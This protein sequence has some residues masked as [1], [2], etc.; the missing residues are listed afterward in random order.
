MEHRLPA[1]GILSILSTVLALA[2]VEGTLIYLIIFAVLFPAAG[3]YKKRITILPS[4]EKILSIIFL[5]V[6]VFEQL[7]TET[8]ILHSLAHCLLLMIALKI[9]K[10][11]SKRELFIV[12][13]ASFA[14]MVLAASTTRSPLLAVPLLIY[15]TSIAFSIR[16][17]MFLEN[18]SYTVA[19]PQALTA[20]GAAILLA[21]G[22]SFIPPYAQ[23]YLETIFADYLGEKLTIY[24]AFS[25][26][27][28]FG[29]IGEMNMNRKVVLRVRS[30]KPVKLK[31]KVFIRYTSDGWRSDAKKSRE[32]LPDEWKRKS[33]YGPVIDREDGKYFSIVPYQKYFG[34]SLQ[35]LSL[36]LGVQ[37][38]RSL[39]IPYNAIG[40]QC[41]LPAVYSDNHGAIYRKASLK[42]I[43]YNC[44]YIP[45][46][47]IRYLKGSAIL[48]PGVVPD[49]GLITQVPD[50]LKSLLT[51]VA[52]QI[53]DP[54]SSF[55]KKI[56][57]TMM[58]ISNNY[59]YSTVFTSTEGYDPV[60]YFLQHRKEGNCE[61]F[62]SAFAL[63]LRV[64]GIQTRYV[65]GFRM[66]EKNPLADYYI[67]RERDAHAWIEAF[68]P[69]TGWRPFDA[70]P[71]VL[72]ESVGHRGVFGY[73]SNGLDL[74]RFKLQGYTTG[75]KTLSIKSIMHG[76]RTALS[77]VGNLIKSR[78]PEF[79]VFCIAI[80]SIP[81]LVRKICYMFRKLKN[82]L[83]PGKI[84]PGDILYPEKIP[85]PY[86][87]GHLRRLFV[88]FEEF[89]H[90][91]EIFRADS[92]TLQEYVN[93]LENNGINSFLVQYGKQLIYYYHQSR[94]G[95][96]GV[97]R[98]DLEQLSR[99]WKEIKSRE[100][101]FRKSHS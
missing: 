22:I 101:V 39:F 88:E 30:D 12:Y 76:M 6:L 80:I 85:Q 86:S 11:K 4:T 57:K 78:I 65:T 44:F 89:M 67:V 79:L 61:L 48:I 72:E 29:E 17:T 69:G 81:F 34:K 62:A 91:E 26:I 1:W 40:I 56:G 7:F 73:L 74:I 83:A 24:S 14:V 41:F 37:T 32:I 95:H 27:S 18:A 66:V 49:T 68:I 19:S 8:H 43:T 45:E 92:Q 15:G 98:N 87:L 59:T 99:T 50:K 96:D 75:V 94:Y 60:E 100:Q 10:K 16:K 5:I 23:I 9:V 97:D 47:T 58:W 93:E 77:R 55:L 54:E 42:G 36:L 51:G 38:H 71:S 63:L 64:Q 13:F 33:V 25:G 53:I 28:S 52:D 3:L 31:G 35:K 21:V 82:R 46:K 84:K 20:L 2:L 70:T 90:N